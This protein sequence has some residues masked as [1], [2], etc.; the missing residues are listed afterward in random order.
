MED[1]RVEGRRVESHP[2][3]NPPAE[4]SPVDGSPLADSASKGPPMGRR[5]DPRAIAPVDPFT[6]K[7]AYEASRRRK[8]RRAAGREVGSRRS[9]RWRSV[10]LG[11]GLILAI[12]IGATGSLLYSA[13]TRGTGGSLAS[14]G[15]STSP[16]PS[17][18][19]TSTTATTLAPD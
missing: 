10:A 3:E 11:L 2:A 13:V 18:T 12:L 6:G 9:K 19:A 14:P 17:T 8:A 7:P 5:S 1:F 16:G 15:V 4:G